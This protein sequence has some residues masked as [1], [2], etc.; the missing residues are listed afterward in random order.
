MKQRNAVLDPSALSKAMP[1]YEAVKQHL[2]EQIRRGVLG[3]ND[4]VPSEN[5]IVAELGVSR[6]TANRALRELA[7]SGRIV[8]VHGV[9]S[10]V[11]EPKPSS[12]LL[13]VRNIAD[14]I[15]ERGHVHTVRVDLLEECQATSS[16]QEWFGWSGSGAL[17]HSTMVH[18]E[19][20][21]PI[22]I[23][24]RFVNPDVGPDYLS[25][26][27]SQQTANAYLATVAPITRADVSIEAVLPSQSEALSLQ[28]QPGAPCLK[29]KRRTWDRD[30]VVTVVFA[31]HP[32]SRFELTNSSGPQPA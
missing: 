20:G 26:D 25:Q 12:T 1:L 23:E 8:R 10:F 13:E 27:F 21:I 17:F 9:G 32:G 14:E 28:I 5:E 24:D 2:E 3:P 30:R 16:L 7:A 18:Y 15:A 6:M 22:Q 11:A 29:L 19:D 31:L 4:R